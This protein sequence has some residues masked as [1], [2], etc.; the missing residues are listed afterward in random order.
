MNQ[1]Q[2]QN[3]AFHQMHLLIQKGKYVNELKA[4]WKRRWELDYPYWSDCTGEIKEMGK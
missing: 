3:L 1:T 4:I 2:L